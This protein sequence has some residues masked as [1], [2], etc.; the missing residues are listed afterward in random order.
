M[1]KICK[2]KSTSKVKLNEKPK[3]VIVPGHSSVDIKLLFLIRDGNVGFS[4]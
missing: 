2:F 3:C 4:M 1:E